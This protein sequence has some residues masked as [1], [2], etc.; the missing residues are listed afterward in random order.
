M[1]CLL[2]ASACEVQPQVSQVAVESQLQAHYCMP[3]LMLYCSL[4][5][6]LQAL[7]ASHY[8]TEATVTVLLKERRVSPASETKPGKA[9]NNVD[10]VGMGS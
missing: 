10:Y 5:V 9:P 8:V 4:C 2:H 7:A 1:L 3:S 6:A